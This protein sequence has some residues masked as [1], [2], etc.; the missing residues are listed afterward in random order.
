MNGKLWNMFYITWR[1]TR[2]HMTHR[3][4]EMWHKISCT[5]YILSDKGGVNNCK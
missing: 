4:T 3:R 2:V 1:A 5:E